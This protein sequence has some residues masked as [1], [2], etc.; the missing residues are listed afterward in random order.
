MIQRIFS[1][2]IKDKAIISFP[3]NAEIFCVKSE[4][5][6]I[7]LYALCSLSDQRERNY[8]NIIIDCFRTGFDNI[9]TEVTRKYLGTVGEYHYFQRID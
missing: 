6:K 9:D 2:N 5:N 4:G 7:M 1:R 3:K 8:E